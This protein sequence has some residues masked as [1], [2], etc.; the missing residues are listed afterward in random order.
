MTHDQIIAT[1]NGFA[2]KPRLFKRFGRWVCFNYVGMLCVRGWGDTP[3]EA[4]A[5]WEGQCHA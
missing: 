1:S 4:F 2:G 3:R 5:H